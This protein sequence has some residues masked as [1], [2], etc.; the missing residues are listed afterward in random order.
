MAHVSIISGLTR[1]AQRPAAAAL[2]ILILNLMP[3]RAVTERQ[4]AELFARLEVP[5]ALTFCLPDSHRLHNNEADIRA[6]YTSFSDIAAQSFDGLI[7]TGA[8]LDRLAFHQIDFW[9]ELHKILAWR[10]THVAGS[11]FICWAAYAAGAIDGAFTGRQLTRKVSGVYTTSGLT[12]PQSRFFTIP[13]NAVRRGQIIAGDD[14]LG[15]TLIEDAS[16][17]SWYLA[18]HLEYQTGTLR[19]EYYRD[20]HKDQT[21]PLPA[22]YFDEDYQPHNTW[23]ADATY[24]YSAWLD[25]LQPTWRRAHG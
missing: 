11:L 14:Q 6:A 2:K 12:M 1:T 10:H 18:G 5:V 24:V 16:S 19:A 17:N 3:N 15:A 13:Q 4:F 9:P 25:S 20:Y 21:T 8:P 23:Q 7:I 22:H